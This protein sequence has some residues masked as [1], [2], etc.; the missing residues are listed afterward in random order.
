MAQIEHTCFFILFT[1]SIVFHL[2]IIICVLLDET[3]GG[4]ECP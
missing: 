2:I 1:I 3:W 4:D